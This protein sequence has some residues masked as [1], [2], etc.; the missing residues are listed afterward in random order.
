MMLIT[1][2]VLFLA[3]ANVAMLILSRAV[4][5]GRELAVRS[6]LGATRWRLVLQMLTENLLLSAAGALGG[7]L[8][9]AWIKDWV[10]FENPR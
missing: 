6:A 4:K 1:F 2:F 9:A 3:C 10:T 8:A 5:R 7:T